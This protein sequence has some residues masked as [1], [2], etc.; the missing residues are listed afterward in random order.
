MQFLTPHWKSNPAYLTVRDGPVFAVNQTDFDYDMDVAPF[1]WLAFCTPHGAGIQAR[2]WWYDDSESL[3]VTNDGTVDIFTAAP[4]GIGEDSDDFGD[5][6]LFDSSL[7]IDVVDL[8]VTYRAKW[9]CGSLE[10]GAGIRYARIEQTYD[11][12]ISELG[13]EVEQINSRHD[14]EGIGPCFSLEG[15]LAATRR[16]TLFGTIRYC[17]L[18]G[19]AEQT[20][21]LLEG[22][23]LEAQAFQEN[24]DVRAV[25]ELDLGAEYACRVACAELYLSVALV[26][27]VWQGAGNSANDDYIEIIDDDFD[28]EMPS[29]NKDADLGLWGLRTEAG[30]RF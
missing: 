13:G 5:Q 11:A 23:L 12:I 25:A 1:V 10:F 9:D 16:I 30:V 8:L 21:A 27:Q 29:A 18:F 7:E 6:L 17:L 26:S 14:F 22:G 28:E 3:A 15:R 24:D 4:L 2:A 20:V 19:R